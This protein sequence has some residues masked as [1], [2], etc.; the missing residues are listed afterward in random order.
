MKAALFG[1]LCALSALATSQPVKE[2]FTQAVASPN[3]AIPAFRH[4]YLMIRPGFDLAE[5]SVYAPDGRFAYDKFVELSEGDGRLSVAQV[6][7]VDFDA[8]GNAALAAAAGGITQCK[9][10]G[11]LLLDQTGRQTGFID[12][13]CYLPAHIA[14]A[15][16][17]SIWTVVMELDSAGMEDRQD[18]M[19]VRHFSLDGKQLKAT[20]PRSS[21]PKGLAPGATFIGDHV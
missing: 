6:S 10:R 4:G 17:H 12:T 9:L 13:G 14:F 1:A 5:F 15:P 7:D 19:V 20:L 11:V 21:F 2:V 3:L 8:E 18:Y 16:D